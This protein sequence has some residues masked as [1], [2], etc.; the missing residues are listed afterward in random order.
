MAKRSTRVSLAVP[1]RLTASGMQK[2]FANH[3]AEA[4][5][6][7]AK[8]NIIVYLIDAIGTCQISKGKRTNNYSS[9]RILL[10]LQR[11]PEADAL[12]HGFRCCNPLLPS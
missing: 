6:Y 7:I 8:N 10:L 9:V 4:K 11:S 12:Q 2:E 1:S 5:R 3:S